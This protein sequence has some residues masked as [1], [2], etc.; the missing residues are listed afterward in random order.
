MNGLL[1]KFAPAFRVVRQFLKYHGAPQTGPGAPFSRVTWPPGH[2]GHVILAAN[3]RRNS[4]CNKE[5][6]L[7]KQS[8]GHGAGVPPGAQ[9]FRAFFQK[10]C[11][12]LLIRS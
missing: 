4:F 9:D 12:L 1:A 2:A 8:R 7:R 10:F 3:L 11:I 5:K 6:R